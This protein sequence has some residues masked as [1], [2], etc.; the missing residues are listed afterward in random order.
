M[1]GFIGLK[2]YLTASSTF[3]HFK[4][5]W[6]C[7]AGEIRK[8]KVDILKVQ[9]FDLLAP[10]PKLPPTLQTIERHRDLCLIKLLYFLTKS[11]RVLCWYFCHFSD[12]DHLPLWGARLISVYFCQDNDA[13]LSALLK[14]SSIVCLDI[15]SPLLPPSSSSSP[16][17]RHDIDAYPIH[18]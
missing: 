6:Y 8:C 9:E 3:A 1:T 14:S 2:L 5:L 11:A 10:V 13:Y 4:K 18:V 17:Y 16:L 15:I 7:A 12:H